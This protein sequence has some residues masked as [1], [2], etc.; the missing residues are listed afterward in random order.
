MSGDRVNNGRIC[1]YVHVC[2][3]LCTVGRCEHT[4]DTG[5]PNAPILRLVPKVFL[6]ATLRVVPEV[7]L[8]AGDCW[9][10]SHACLTVDCPNPFAEPLELDKE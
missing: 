2:T 7:L 4:H 1:T 5:P 9:G 10:L 6:P 3:L 8:R